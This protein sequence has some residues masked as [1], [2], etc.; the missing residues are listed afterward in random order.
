MPR[1]SGSTAQVAGDPGGA[2]VEYTGATNLTIRGP[3]SG[4]VYRFVSP[5]ARMIVDGRD[6]AFLLAIPHLSKKAVS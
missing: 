2:V 4:L 1:S 5:G 6:A 3:I